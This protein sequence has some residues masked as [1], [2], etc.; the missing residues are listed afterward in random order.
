VAR[1]M[2][3]TFAAE[4]VWLDDRVIVRLA[5]EL[6]ID[7][8]PALRGCLERVSLVGQHELVLDLSELEFCDSTGIGVFVEWQR[9]A[10]D[11]GF[12]LV[13]RSPRAHLRRLLEFALLD[14]LVET[15]TADADAARETDQT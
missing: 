10:R 14:G 6:D 8:A 15:R 5:G 1:A 12:E 4:P 11:G 3:D 7:S 9:R 13:L 2:A